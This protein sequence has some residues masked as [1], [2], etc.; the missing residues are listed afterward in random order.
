MGSFKGNAWDVYDTMGTWEWT[1]SKYKK[2]YDG[3]EQK[4][5]TKIQSATV[6]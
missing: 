1:C 6:R 2:D 4:C 3:S 5:T